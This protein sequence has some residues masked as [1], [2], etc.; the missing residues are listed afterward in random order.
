MD[1]DVFDFIGLLY[2]Y[3]DTNT[4]DTRFDKDLFVFIAGNSQ[5]IEEEFG[6]T[7]CFDF[8][9]IVSF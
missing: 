7:G 8:G 5:R 9:N 4:V 1:Q 2:S 3:A 6:R